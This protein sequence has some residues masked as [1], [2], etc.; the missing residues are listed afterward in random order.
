MAGTF[1]R[2]GLS[3]GSAA[4]DSVCRVVTGRALGKARARLPSAHTGPVD[5]IAR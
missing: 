2:L 5:G 3:R 4:P 1:G